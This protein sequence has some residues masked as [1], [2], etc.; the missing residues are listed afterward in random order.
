MADVPRPDPC[1]ACGRPL[2]P[3]QGRGRRRRYCGARCRD[4]ARRARARTPGARQAGVKESLTDVERHEYLDAMADP[5]G[6]GDAPPGRAGAG[7]PLAAVAAARDRAVAADA[8]LQDAVDQARAAG[9]SWRE[10]GDVLGT[11]RQAAFQRFGRPVDLRTGLAMSRAVPPG[12]A[13]R[14]V[15]IFAW[16]DEGRW[17]DIIEQLNDDMRGTHSPAL[18][19]RGQAA[20]TSHFGRLE[21]IGEPYARQVGDDTVVIVPLHFE[22]GDARGMVRF[23]ADGKVAGMAIRPASTP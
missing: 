4:A 18:L 16:H 15:A 1:L 9:H 23:A 22:A 20:V 5:P 17:A 21:R 14:A 13:D 12:A 19:A 3:Q 7:A 11:T 8:A 6:G 2:P 10:V